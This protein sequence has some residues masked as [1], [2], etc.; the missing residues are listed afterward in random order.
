M[1]DSR[2][3]TPFADSVRGILLAV[4]FRKPR[5]T[6]FDKLHGGFAT[7]VLYRTEFLVVQFVVLLKKRDHLVE[8]MG[9]EILER[10][11]PAMRSRM[12]CY[13]NEPVVPTP[14]LVLVF[15]ARL[16]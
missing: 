13:P 10:V 1:P 9:T 12:R 6:L 8:Q 11:S 15:S 4:F 16:R 3:S 2:G 14:V 5:L 7:T